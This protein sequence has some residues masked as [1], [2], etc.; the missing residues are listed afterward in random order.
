VLGR[1][2]V[3]LDVRAVE[4]YYLSRWQI[5]GGG[6]GGQMR[7]DE[8]EVDGRAVGLQE[9]VSDGITSIIN[10]QRRI[11]SQRASMGPTEVRS[12]PGSPKDDRQEIS[13]LPRGRIAPGS[14][15]TGIAGGLVSV[16][17]YIYCLMSCGCIMAIASENRLL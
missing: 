9:E 15:C 12:L 11:P 2:V 3:C 10:V 5:A 16:R 8:A 17:M 6:A 14:C 7:A 13:S 4:R 1:S